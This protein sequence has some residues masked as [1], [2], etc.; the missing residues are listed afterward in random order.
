MDPP[1]VAKRDEIV[2][3]LADRDKQ[4]ID[5]VGESPTMAKGRKEVPKAKAAK[6]FEAALQAFHPKDSS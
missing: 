5:L 3:E 2:K 1:Q 6:S 4:K